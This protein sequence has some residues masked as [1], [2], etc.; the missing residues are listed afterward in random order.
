[1]QISLSKKVISLVVFTLILELVIVGSLGFLHQQAEREAD[2]ANSSARISDAINILSRELYRLLAVLSV[3]SF[4]AELFRSGEIARFRESLLSQYETLKNEERN[5]PAELSVVLKSEK[6]A[7]EG[8]AILTKL[9]TD[10]QALASLS[11]P[12]QCRLYIQD[13]K[14]KGR[15]ILSDDFVDLNRKQK[16]IARRSP[17]KQAE[18]RQQQLLVLWIAV[19]VN[20]FVSMAAAVWLVRNITGRLKIMSENASRL[21]EGKSLNPVLSGSDEIAMLDRRFHE[22]AESLE[23]STRLRESLIAMMTH[24]LKTPLS[25]LSNFLELLEERL[26]GELNEK[27]EP[28]LLMANNSVMQMTK[29]VN[30]MLDLEKVK[31]GKISVSQI[32]VSIAALVETACAPLVSLAAADGVSLEVQSVNALVHVDVDMIVR[33][34][35]NL[36]SNAIK[37]SRSG[38]KVSLHVERLGNRITVKVCDQGAGIPAQHLDTVFERY[39]QVPGT[40]KKG[41]GLGLAICK[42]FVELN[43]GKISIE[44]KENQ[45]TTVCFELPLAESAR[46]AANE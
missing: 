40:E 30:D 45:G 37:F 6:A 38:S 8:L 11:N 7:R 31:D 21:A 19:L 36:I 5:N 13:L 17:I 4:S 22:M 10:E 43:A 39:A 32:D 34:I 15:F 12:E 24:D 28:M 25:F 33:V 41:A 35:T 44:S 14:G 27:G 46:S 26:L 18:I 20:I 9:E 23:E 3:K 16:A 29:L 1:M 42:A 2:R